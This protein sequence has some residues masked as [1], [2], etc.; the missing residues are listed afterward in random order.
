[1]KVKDWIGSLNF[2]RNSRSAPPSPRDSQSQNLNGFCNFKTKFNKSPK[3][4][5]KVK[6]LIFIEIQQVSQGSHESQGLNFHRNSTSAPG[7]RP[8][9]KSK[10]EWIL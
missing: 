4:H 9:P 7:A 3:G 1:M 8:S 5:M 6:V 2:H 10:F